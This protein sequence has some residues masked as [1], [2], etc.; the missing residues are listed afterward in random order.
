VRTIVYGNE[1]TFQK[2]FIDSNGIYIDPLNINFSI[3]R[4]INTILYGPFVYSTSSTPVTISGNFEKVGIGVYN[5]TQFIED[6]IVPGIYAAKWIAD[7]DGVDEVYYENFQVIEPEVST[8]RIIDPSSLYGKIIEKPLYSDLSLGETDRIALIGHADGL[9]LNTPHR[10]IDI[11][12]TINT[13]GADED[14]PLLRGMFEA[15]NMGAKD[16][17]LI[18]SAP[19]SEYVPYDQIDGTSRKTARVDLNNLTFYQKY[20]QRLDA[21]YR[22][23]MEEDFPEIVVPLEAPFLDAGDVDFLTPL[24]SNCLQRYRKTG[25]VSIGILGTRIPANTENVFEKLNTDMR[26]SRFEGDSYVYSTKTLFS[27]LRYHYG[28]DLFSTS[29]ETNILDG[30]DM[31]KFGMVVVGEGLSKAPQLG[32][33]YT[34]SLAATVAGLMASMPENQSIVNKKLARISGL[35]GYIF[36]KEEVQ[37]LA[38]KRLNVATLTPL[39]RRGTSYQTFIATDNSLANGWPD[40]NTDD[41]SAF[42]AVSTLR[43]VG[44][45]SQQIVALGRRSL[46]TIEYAM[47]KDSIYSYLDS[48]QSDGLLKDYRLNIYRE[49]DENRTVYVDLMLYPYFTIREIYFTVEVGP[50]TGE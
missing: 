19:M 18:A 2:N 28:I 4:N 46:G 16:I 30:Q 50:G 45:I 22:I 14:S 35:V 33:P 6:V 31:G 26:I 1:I 32:Y 25:N 11:Q 23:L 49:Q 40:T 20:S 12:E 39:G 3:V 9:E 38:R 36:T 37:E 17:W 43:L 8:N 47:F 21:T 44:K 15:Y 24:L 48:L 7:V 13:L 27:I 42:W 41:Q 34:T 29:S 5:Y 10:V